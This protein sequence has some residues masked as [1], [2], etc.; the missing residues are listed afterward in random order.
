MK[1]LANPDTY[2]HPLI[3]LL[4]MTLALVPMFVLVAL[5]AAKLGVP[6]PVVNVQSSSGS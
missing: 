4:A 1:A 2:D 5:G 6:F 3:F